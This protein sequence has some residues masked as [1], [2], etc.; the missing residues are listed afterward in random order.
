MNARMCKTSGRPC[1]ATSRGAG[2][3]CEGRTAEGFLWIEVAI[4]NN[5]RLRGTNREGAHAQRL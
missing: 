5:G 3:G 4:Q 2:T 1:V